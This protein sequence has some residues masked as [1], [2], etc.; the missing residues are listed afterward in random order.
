MYQPSRDALPIYRPI[1]GRSSSYRREPLPYHD[2]G[3]DRAQMPDLNPPVLPSIS[4]L[5]Q[6][7]DQTEENNLPD[8]RYRSPSQGPRSPVELDRPMYLHQQQPRSPRELD[9]T[10]KQSQSPLALYSPGPPTPSTSLFDT[11]E[12]SIP[13]QNSGPFA[14][15]ARLVILQQPISARACGYGDK[16][17]RMIDPP[18]ILTFEV[19]DN[20]TGQV[21]GSKERNKLLRGF[22]P[23]VHCSL[24][25]PCTNSVDDTIE[26]SVDRRNQRR[27]VGSMVCNGYKTALSHGEERFYFTFADLSVRF[28]GEYQLMFRLTL[29][30]Q[31]PLMMKVSNAIISPLLSDIFTVHNAKDFEGM[32]PSSDLAKALVNQGY[33][34]ILKIKKGNAKTI[35]LC[36]QGGPDGDGDEDE[37]MED[38]AGGSNRKRRR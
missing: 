14:T 20:E 4:T 36:D 25:N 32:R 23:V 29:I 18:P 10:F 1:D 8:D 3:D 31:A 6:S 26:G 22:M 28:P 33:P 19:L 21:V 30:D 7:I 17:R 24:W 37:E 11:R 12:R 2:N 15:P 13:V 9:R 34:N 35:A 16:D 27:M 38:M 5:I